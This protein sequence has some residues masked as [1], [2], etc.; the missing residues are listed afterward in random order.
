MLRSLSFC[1]IRDTN[2]I[3]Y[4]ILFVYVSHRPQVYHVYVCDHAVKIQIYHNRVHLSYCKTSRKIIQNN[5]YDRSLYISRS[6]NSFHWDQYLYVMIKYRTIDENLFCNIII[7]PY[8]NE[9]N[10]LY[11]A[12]FSN[13]LSILWYIYIYISVP[14]PK[15]YFYPH[16]KHSYKCNWKNWCQQF[17]CEQYGWA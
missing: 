6:S 1:I 13:V 4:P 17:D 11:F 16:I 8:F 10:E 5:M 2:Y 14:T 7:K 3:S 12:I 15:I 9:F